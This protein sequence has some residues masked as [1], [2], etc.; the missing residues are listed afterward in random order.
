MTTGSRLIEFALLV[1]PSIL[2]T[3]FA[4]Q[5]GAKAARS[6][7]DGTKAL[8][9]VSQRYFRLS[10]KVKTRA[11][12]PFGAAAQRICQPTD[13]PANGYA[14]QRI[15]QY[16]LWMARHKR[17]RASGGRLVVPVPANRSLAAVG[18][19]CETVHAPNNRVGAKLS[20]S[21]WGPRL[22]SRGHSVSPRPHP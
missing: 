14:S 20:D 16:R 15:W 21:G 2:P 8:I 11:R 9:S 13:L 17:F 19:V 22:A 6:S 12:V 10:L 3:N 5:P 4:L 18:N 7:D 1:S